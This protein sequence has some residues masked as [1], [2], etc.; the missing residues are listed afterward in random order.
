MSKMFWYFHGSTVG[1]CLAAL[2][3]ST[4]KTF[5]I[6]ILLLNAVMLVACWINGEFD[7]GIH[8]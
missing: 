2:N 3:T 7:A 4:D 8:S 6:M 5:P 1:I